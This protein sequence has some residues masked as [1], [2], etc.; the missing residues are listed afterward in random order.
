MGTIQCADG[1]LSVKVT[2][3]GTDRYL[4]ILNIPDSWLECKLGDY[5]YH[6]GASFELRD[7]GETLTGTGYQAPHG[8]H[9]PVTLVATKTLSAG[10]HTI[11]ARWSMYEPCPNTGGALKQGQ[12]PGWLVVIRADPQDLHG[13]YGP[14]SQQS[15]G[16]SQDWSDLQIPSITIPK[17]GGD[18]L[19]ILT[20]TP[21]IASPGAPVH[22][23]L[24]RVHEGTDTDVGFAHVIHTAGAASQSFPVTLVEAANL[25]GGD[26]IRAQWKNW[27]TGKVEMIPVGGTINV[28]WLVALRTPKG[29][30]SSIRNPYT[31]TSTTSKSPVAVPNLPPLV[32][33][34]KGGRY[35]LA[36]SV[37]ESRTCAYAPYYSAG[38]QL[39]VD[40]VA[41]LG[42]LFSA[43]GNSNI[44][45]C[46]TLP[47]T[48]FG[49]RDLAAGKHNLTAEWHTSGAAFGSGNV[50]VKVAKLLALT[51]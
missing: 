12:Y 45:P 23:R 15:L 51:R 1:D 8:Q 29:V 38:F 47:M 41:E 37:T 40:G 11:E 3:N 39:H 24:R 25:Q 7:G 5:K 49:V 22:Y 19:L 26:V 13:V 43:H 33:A 21:T 14:S 28:S 50:S 48:L 35:L 9:M 30:L 32:V 42:G 2:A 10:E 17:P 20:T 18:Y 31:E 36:F 4:F 27:S 16:A 34:S 44:M 6:R 46:Q